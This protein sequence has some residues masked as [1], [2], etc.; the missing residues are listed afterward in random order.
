MSLLLRTICEMVEDQLQDELQALAARV[1]YLC[2]KNGEYNDQIHII[3]CAP[4]VRTFLLACEDQQHIIL[5]RGFC[6]FIDRNSPTLSEQI[7][8]YAKSTLQY[9]VEE[10]KQ[11]ESMLEKNTLPE[12]ST[13]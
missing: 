4:S 1:S 5:A 2:Y 9:V 12:N 8:Q 7:I 3:T 6:R 11:Y 13:A 10:N